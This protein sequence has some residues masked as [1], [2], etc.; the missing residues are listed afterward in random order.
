VSVV[1]RRPAVLAAILACSGLPSCGGSAA[2]LDRAQLVKRAD[3]ICLKVNRQ[4]ASA[5]AALPPSGRSGDARQAFIAA[6][7]AT[8][9]LSDRGLAEL[10]TLRPPGSMA[11]DWR[12]FLA[13]VQAQD[14]GEHRLVQAARRGDLRGGE[15]IQLSMQHAAADLQQLVERDG[16]SVCGRLQRR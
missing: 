5:V 14:A 1:I 2:S 7:Q 3:A 15:A 12:R 8:L 6:T 13:D 11:T 16:F 10:R 9:P 4:A